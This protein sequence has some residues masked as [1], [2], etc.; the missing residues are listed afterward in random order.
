MLFIN[1]GMAQ[2]SYGDIQGQLFENSETDRPAMYAKVWVER[3]ASRFGADTD[4]N[5][6]FK[7]NSIP[8]GVYVLKINYLGD[9]LSHTV[10]ANVLTDGIAHLKRINFYDKLTDRVT[11][12]VEVDIVTL[13]RPLINHDIGQTR[14]DPLDIMRSAS[15]NDLNTLIV[16]YNSDIK[17]D[18]DGQ[19]IIR[20]SRGNDLIHYIDGVKTGEVQGIPSSAIGGITVYT[21]AI[22]AS[23]GDTTGGVI[24]METKSYYDLWRAWKLQQS[25]AQF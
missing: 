19:M 7:I 22:P 5:G 24:I 17:V 23:Y 13:R 16:S 2:G 18:A 20:G 4:E 1:L 10:V 15:K 14:I 3:G 8:S 11:E 9:T 25:A 12:I 21:S 6:R